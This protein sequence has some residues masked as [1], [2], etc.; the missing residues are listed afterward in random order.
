MSRRG[1][2]LTLGA[3]F[4]GAAALAHVRLHNP[5]TGAE[6]FWS[7][8]SNISV[9]IQSDGSDNIDD[10][11]VET[12]LESAIASWNEATGTTAQLVENTSPSQKARTDWSSS[13]IH[14]L[15]FDETNSSGYFP[16]GSG[17]VA[18]TPIWFFGNGTVS[19]ADVLF[20]G[21]GFQFT[22]K[23][24]PNA[25]DVGD[26]ATHELGH[27]LGLDHSGVA[28]AS[29]YPYVDPSVILHRSVSLDDVHGLRAAYPDESFASLT[30]RVR[31]TNGGAGVAG[32]WVSARDAE[33]RFAGAALANSAGN[34]AILGLDAGE[35]TIY[36]RPLDE[37]VSSAN[38][39]SGYT[40]VTDFEPAYLA[41][42]QSLV[43][44]ADLFVGDLFVGAD[45]TLSLGR[46][47]DN[48]PL[49]V[50]R[51]TSTNLQIHG[52]GLT[53]GATLIPGDS[54]FVI[55]PSAWLGS[56]ANFSVSAPS[57]AAPG[58]VDLEVVD[59]AG[60]R[61]ILPGAL[62]IT[63][64]D[65]VL[66]TVSPPSG[67]KTGGTALIVK[68]ANFQPGA[69]VVIGDRIYP[70]GEPGGCNVVDDATILLTT[71]VT[72]PGVHD[73]VVIDS[74]GVEGRLTGGFASATLPSLDSVFPIAGNRFGGTEMVLRGAEFAPGL[75]VRID[76]QVQANVVLDSSERVVVTTS[77]GIEGGP[78]QLE[79]E[80]P[81]GGI[82]TSAFTYVRPLDPHIA[83]LSP[84]GGDSGGGDLVTIQGS[85]FTAATEVVFGADP[86]TGMGG[87][88][89][90]AVTFV[91]A[92][93]LIV[94]VPPNSGGS[95]SVLVRRADTEQ[96]DVLASAFTY[97]GGSSKSGGC[98][99][100][101]D[102]GRF[103][104]KSALEGGLW[105]LALFGALL[106]RRRA[107]PVRA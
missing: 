85:N 98:L 86:D 54:R 40:I 60:R 1:W 62:E 61:S 82:A 92:N 99:A 63:P 57:D 27:L 91:S 47:V 16:P 10:S 33:G 102:G 55:T 84:D 23:G 94:E 42:V 45:V 69:R 35:Y 87:V 22:T 58:L 43:A 24:G 105:F 50:V 3:L 19:D 4:T 38:L 39:T 68:G 59:F 56:L 44:G 53:T 14:L 72:L 73:V 75:I 28:G 51:G 103:D 37:P 65:P 101:L 41:G 78:Y 97:T 67:S 7:N 107:A 83:S 106:A 71:A 90:N 26:V 80:N 29:M 79:V 20:N 52:S 6:L 96:A 34:F 18:I 2:V 70:D 25:F 32:A 17:T 12:A 30:G 48:F 15:W 5:G 49:R 31:R 88:A 76:G 8:P 95:K 77:S 9:V 36:A 100:R 104:P 66:S 81:G 13:S 46:I 89:A 64:P 93:T 11:S 74:S 21:K